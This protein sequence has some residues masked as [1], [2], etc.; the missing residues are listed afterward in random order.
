MDRCEIEDVL[1]FIDDAEVEL[2]RARKCMDIDEWAEA[3]AH[4]SKA[5]GLA[6]DACIRLERLSRE[7]GEG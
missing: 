6:A 2:E 7:E 4:A 1:G 3:C 5:E